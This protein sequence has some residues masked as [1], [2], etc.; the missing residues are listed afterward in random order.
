MFRIFL[1]KLQL[2]RMDAEFYLWIKLT[3]FGQITGRSRTNYGLVGQIT[4]AIHRPIRTNYGR[5][6]QIHWVLWLFSRTN[7]GLV[8]RFGAYG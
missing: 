6:P 1:K 5:Y 8:G 7:Y 2:D 3:L 4:G